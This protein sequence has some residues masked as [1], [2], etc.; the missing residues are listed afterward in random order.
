MK[1]KELFHLTDKIAIVTGGGSGIGRRVAMA[2]SEFG[3]KLLIADIDQKAADLVVSEIKSKGGEAIAIR[4]DVTHPEEV[5]EMVHTAANTFGRIDILFNNAG[6]S[7]RGPAESFSLE[8]WN[9][10]IAVDLTGMFICAQAVGKVM[11]KQGRGKIINTAS[12]SAK[13]GHPGNLAYAAAKHGV[14]GMSKVMAVEWGKY[15]VSVNC[16][17]PGVINTP[18]TMKAFSDTEKYQELVRKVPLGRLGEPGDLIGAAVFLASE[19]SN[20]VTGQ[21][22]YIEGGRMSD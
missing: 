22:I 8:D 13:L 17:G 5:H 7:I 10:V 20:Y 12:V 6:I 2:F 4:M 11:I 15:G 1:D 14:V 16:I 18:M 3:A 19:A 9:K 21:T